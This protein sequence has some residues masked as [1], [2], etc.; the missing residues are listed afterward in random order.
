MVKSFG[1][2]PE[3]LLQTAARGIDDR[4]RLRIKRFAGLENA[5][6]IGHRV[7]IALNRPHVALVHDALHVFL[8]Q[9]LDPDHPA[10]GQQDI[11]HAALGD[12]TAAGFYDTFFKA[13]QYI[14]QGFLFQA[15]IA[16]LA[17]IMRCSFVL[18]P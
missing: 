11:E 9:G 13:R 17:S 7:I 15:T 16:V 12:D 14:K 6:Q 18:R 3:T 1:N 5:T 2:F 8:G 10:G 4:V